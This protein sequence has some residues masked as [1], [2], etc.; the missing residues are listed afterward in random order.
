M[1]VTE[2]VVVMMVTL[3]LLFFYEL[4]KKWGFFQIYE[5]GRRWVFLI[6]MGAGCY[7]VYVVVFVK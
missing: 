5:L 4:D 1:L 2:S 7:M 6:S 3:I